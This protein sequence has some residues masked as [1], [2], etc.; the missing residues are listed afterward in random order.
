MTQPASP[1]RNV[2]DTARWV[3]FYRAMESER[4]DALFLDPFARRLAGEQGEAIVNAMP[5]G[6]PGGR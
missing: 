3:A 6:A 4:P 2:S 1:I 5:K